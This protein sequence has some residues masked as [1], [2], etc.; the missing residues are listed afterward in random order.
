MTV[1]LEVRFPWGRF[2]ATP[3]GR[4]ANEAAPEWPP[5]PWRLLRALYAVWRTRVPH[6]DDGVVTGL[7]TKLADPP[8]FRLPDHRLAHTRHYLPDHQ[9]RRG[10]AGGTDKVFDA[11]V[12]VDRDSPVVI[13]WPNA[14]LTPAEVQALD[15]LCANLA[16][17][18]RSE[19]LCA[20]STSAAADDGG[21]WLDVAGAAGAEETVGVLVAESPLDLGALLQTTVAV[22]KAGFVDPPGSRRVRY[23]AVH[24][25]P[26]TSA[27]RRSPPCR[28]TVALF[29]VTPADGKGALPQ[30]TAAVGMGEMLRRAA[31]SR[32]ELIIG[33]DQPPSPTFSGKGADGR[34]LDQHQHAHFLSYPR[35]GARTIDHLVVWAPE[36]LGSGEVSALAAVRT[37]RPGARGGAEGARDLRS[38][39]VGLAALG[40][41]SVLGKLAGTS[42]SWTSL[43]PF[44]TARHLNPATRRR[45]ADDDPWPAFLALE[46]ERELALRGLALESITPRASAGGARWLE[47]RRHR[48]FKNERRAEARRPA[49]FTIVL[50]EATQGPLVLG[51]LA[52]FGLGLFVPRDI[53]DG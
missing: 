42:T 40:D 36:G 16:Y 1:T 33:P 39:D 50:R 27:L 35:S 10:G 25:A 17:F 23:A 38:V 44:V 11:F 4:S 45:I 19:S 31:Q 13:R 41:E 12:A 21:S 22:R 26:P 37:L 28:P 8:A 2:H 18:G 24:E 5:S 9:H 7:L 32:Y 14:R 52:H 6:L 48:A 53:D 51:A 15:T 46:V 34:R 49:G 30:L 20:V 29:S 3:W 43:T 47:F